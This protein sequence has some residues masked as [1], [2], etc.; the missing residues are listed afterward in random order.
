MY[1]RGIMLE[2]QPIKIIEITS[3]HISNCNLNND[4][5]TATDAESSWLLSPSLEIESEESPEYS[6]EERTGATVKQSALNIAKCCMGT[7][8]LALPYAASQGGLLFN[9]LGLAGISLWCVYSVDRLIK[10]SDIVASKEAEEDDDNNNEDGKD[11]SST[12]SSSSC[13]RPPSGISTMGKV[14]WYCFGPIGLHLVDGMM[15]ILLIGVVTAY[16]DAAIGFLQQSSISTKSLYLDALCTLVLIAP[17]SCVPDVGFLSKYSA[18]GLLTILAS[19]LTIFAYGILQNGLFQ[20]LFNITWYDLWPQSIS[21]CSHWFGIVVFSYGLV[22]VIYNIQESMTQPSRINTATEIAL[23]LVFVVY[24]IISDGVA[25][26][27]S[28][29]SSIEYD[30]STLIRRHYFDG[31][32][33]QHLPVKGLLPE[34]IRLA[35]TGVI[36]VT[37]PLLVIPC[38][39]LVE[40]RIFK[41]SSS[42]QPKTKLSLKSIVVRVA[43]C[44]MCTCVSVFIPDFVSIVS[45]IGCFSVALVSFV[46]PPLFYVV[47]LCTCCSSTARRRGSKLR[48]RILS[49]SPSP[50][51]KK[52]VINHQ[53]MK[54]NDSNGSTASESSCS[55]VNNSPTNNN[56]NTGLEYQNAVFDYSAFRKNI[57]SKK[58]SNNKDGFQ[59]NHLLDC[60]MILCGI[61]TTIIT[62]SLTFR[63]MIISRGVV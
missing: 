58:T 63:D 21:E 25:I 52:G 33:I 4:I 62:T 17:L 43:L 41:D 38:S 14:A 44:T 18:M 15:I 28:P 16:E 27:Y 12:S 31:D 19:F 50:Q 1:T 46:F 45:F 59:F 49:S 54:S 24:V 9:I 60:G 47:L 22:P 2:Q 57:Q 23:W 53:K 29:S 8:T 34:F 11:N 7:G 56:I 61:F 51:K 13:H 36:I 42:H 30:P 10:C 55:S 3:D 48:E 40:G 39:E 32:V 6:T 35:M 26:I 5:E 37:A 20:G